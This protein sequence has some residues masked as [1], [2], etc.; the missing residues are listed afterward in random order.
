MIAAILTSMRATHEIENA[1]AQIE[2]MSK[3]MRVASG[4]VY[5]LVWAAIYTIAS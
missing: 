4:F 3:S 5:M 1:A 2:S